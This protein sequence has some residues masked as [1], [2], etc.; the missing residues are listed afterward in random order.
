[1]LMTRVAVSVFSGLRLISTGNSLPYLR[2]L[3]LHAEQLLTAVTEQALG[4]L[5]DNDEVASPIYDDDRIRCSF[6]KTFERQ[7]ARK[8]EVRQVRT[9]ITHRLDPRLVG[10]R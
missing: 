7:W 9:I 10:D 3:D 8:T 5:V 6:K 1:M 4:K 2:P